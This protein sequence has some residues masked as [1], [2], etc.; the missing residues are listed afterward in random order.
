MVH[1]YIPRLGGLCIGLSLSS[2]FFLSVDCYVRNYV[3]L[4]KV[5][6]S[7][8]HFLMLL[9]LSALISL[10]PWCGNMIFV[11][12]VPSSHLAGVHRLP[13]LDEDSSRPFVFRKASGEQEKATKSVQEIVTSKLPPEL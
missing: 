3:E 13:W 6:R 11:A 4:L 9:V 12:S 7:L 2:P 5:R 8:R 10:L 1:F